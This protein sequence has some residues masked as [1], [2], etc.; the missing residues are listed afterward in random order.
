MMPSTAVKPTVVASVE[1]A[2]V[3]PSHV[4]TMMRTIV[5]MPVMVGTIKTCRQIRARVVNCS[6]SARTHRLNRTPV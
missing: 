1:S 2:G 4:A 3:V 6:G 5:A